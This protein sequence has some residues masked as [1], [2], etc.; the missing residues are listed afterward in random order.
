MK[1]RT[2][3]VAGLLVIIVASM[4]GFWYWNSPDRRV[5]AVLADGETAIETKDLDRAMSHVS[6]QYRDENVDGIRMPFDEF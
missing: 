5:R 4:V 2:W 6:L 1:R 3:V